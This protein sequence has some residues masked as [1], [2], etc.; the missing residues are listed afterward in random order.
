MIQ[1]K[2]PPQFIKYVR[3]FLSG[4][5]TTVSI[6][7]VESD[8]FLM[9]NGLPQGSSIS[10]LLFL[11]FINDFDVE[12]DIETAA[13]LFADDTS[14]WR[15]DGKIRGSHRILMQKEVDKIMEWSEEWKMKVN[16]SKTRSMVIASST[17][18]K[19]W[20]PQLKAG[21]TSIKQEQDYRFLGVTTPSDLIFRKYVE[22]AATKGRNRNKVLKYMATKNWGNSLETQ[23]TIYI[24]YVRSGM[25]YG[26]PSWSPWISTSNI[27]NS[28][29]SKMMPYA[30]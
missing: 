24:Q 21:Q 12:L 2:L 26:G 7:N 30:H 18:D 16:G 28:N 6:N 22:T 19:K 17:K 11:I 29:E 27:K 4:I 3:H 8:P 23:R 14:A 5:K 15:T 9:R 25:E 13:S 10:P 1:L 20:D